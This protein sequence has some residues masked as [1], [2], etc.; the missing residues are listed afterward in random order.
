[1]NKHIED[2]AAA[3]CRAVA[4]LPDRDSPAHWPEAML[5]THAE[6]RQIVIDA[7]GS[8]SPTI[9]PGYVSADQTMTVDRLHDDLRDLRSEANAVDTI[10]GRP[11]L[12]MAKVTQ[13]RDAIGRARNGRIPYSTVAPGA[14]TTAQAVPPDLE[15][16]DIAFSRGV[17]V[18][19]QTVALM[20]QATLWTEIVRACDEEKLLQFAAHVEPEEWELAGFA[21][22]AAQEL[23]RDKPPDQDQG[24]THA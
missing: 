10:I 13:M 20:D 17:C 14:A 7:M 6:L 15:A 22:Y 12:L 4:E 8:A 24:G 2:L 16:L 5:V 9:P 1:M 3:I 11:D 23:G 18:A 19:L 21:Q